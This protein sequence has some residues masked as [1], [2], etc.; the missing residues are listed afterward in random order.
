ML[1]IL[2]VVIVINDNYNEIYSKIFKKSQ[3]LYAKKHGYDFKI[4]RHMLDNRVNHFL[5]CSFQKIL[6]C[7]QEW[8]KNYDYIVSLDADVFINPNAP[9]IHLA[10]DFQDKIGIVNEVTQLPDGLYIKYSGHPTEYY[11]KYL[12]NENFKT[13]LLFNSGVMV[14]QPKIHSDFLYNIFEKYIH[15]CVTHGGFHYEQSSVGYELQINNLYTLLPSKFNAVWGLSKYTP[16]TIHI[17]LE[18]YFSNNYF[19]HLAGSTDWYVADYL[20]NP[21]L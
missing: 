19:I 17:T 15:N 6:V 5:A 20:F 16:E 14:F 7:S 10:C 3:E 1:K 4:I 2:V 21:L 8:S 9:P 11:K 13:E 12:K 18:N